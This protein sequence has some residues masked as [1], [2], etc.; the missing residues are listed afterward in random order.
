MAAICVLRQ[1]CDGPVA[2]K[3]HT[4]LLHMCAKFHAFMTKGT[5]NFY[6]CFTNDALMRREGLKG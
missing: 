1:I 5:I 6:I 4:T 3:F 2:E